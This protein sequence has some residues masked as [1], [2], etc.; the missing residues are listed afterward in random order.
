[1]EAAIDSTAEVTF[2]DFDVYTDG[3]R[4]AAANRRATYDTYC[5]LYD[6]SEALFNRYVDARTE[7]CSS[8]VARDRY[9]TWVIVSG[10]CLD[11][12]RKHD[13]AV[14]SQME[15]IDNCSIRGTEGNG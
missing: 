13:I 15:W 9:D 11:A 4:E 12:Q 2:G 1:M 8:E 6:A 5:A 10:M 3:L 7:P 14:K